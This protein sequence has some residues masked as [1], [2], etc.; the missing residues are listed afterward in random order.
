[1]PKP[2]EPN[3]LPMDDQKMH[4]VMHRLNEPVSEPVNFRRSEDRLDDD[5]LPLTNQQV[6]EI[7]GAMVAQTMVR[8]AMQMEIDAGTDSLTPLKNRKA[9]D[10]FV[11]S[12]RGQ[13]LHDGDMD[14]VY[15]D[16]DKF[17]GVND[18]FG[19]ATGDL[20][21]TAVGRAIFDKLRDGEVGFRHGG[22]EF[23]IF[24]DNTAKADDRRHAGESILGHGERRSGE[25][26]RDRDYDPD[27]LA[28]R[29]TDA[30][31]EARRVVHESSGIATN[32]EVD[33]SFG[34]VR[35]HEGETIDELISRAD[36]LMYENKNA[37][38]RAPESP[39][40]LVSPSVG[41]LLR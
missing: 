39:T 7:R 38:N 11:E 36:Q 16:L 33:A 3:Y 25:D 40:N 15:I 28:S 41:S 10:E 20:V 32:I 29:F 34:Y 27:G 31:E 23:V 1:M 4:E 26:R 21:L 13:I 24:V 12:K 8:N 9:Y 5:N 18:T 19:H 35:S 6:Q 17:K 14:I 30:M 37:V 2:P 22:D